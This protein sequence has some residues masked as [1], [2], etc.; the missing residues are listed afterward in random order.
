MLGTKI[1]H[2][3]SFLGAYSQIL[4]QINKL[5]QHCVVS[6]VIVVN[7]CA[8]RL[9]W[10]SLLRLGV[11]EVFPEEVIVVIVCETSKS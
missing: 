7:T 9:C 1:R 10:V 5:L 2:S 8:V 6:V 11:R 3:L 4:R